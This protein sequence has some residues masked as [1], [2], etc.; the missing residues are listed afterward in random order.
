MI[1]FILILTLRQTI[2]IDVSCTVDV[3][4]IL[5]VVVICGDS[6]VPHDGP[7]CDLLWSD[8]EET[9]GWGVS[10]RG[11]GYLFGSDVV[12][13]FNATNNIDMICRFVKCNEWCGVLWVEI[14]VYLKYLKNVFFWSDPHWRRWLHFKYVV[15]IGG[16]FSADGFQS[17]SV[18]HGGL[19]VALQRT[20][21]YRLVRAELLLSVSTPLW[22]WKP[23]Q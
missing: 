2:C 12:Q 20:R 19:Q 7:M 17:S 13:Q 18:G 8:P 6:K 14:Y 16:T 4:L 1:N 3:W 9:Q 15:L 5:S 11:A 21:A 23:A 22:L 10:P